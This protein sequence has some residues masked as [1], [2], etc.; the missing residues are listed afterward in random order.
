MSLQ[1]GKTIDRKAGHTQ[2]PNILKEDTNKHARHRNILKQ[3]IF[4]KD[5]NLISKIRQSAIKRTQGLELKKNFSSSE[6]SPLKKKPSL[7]KQ[8]SSSI[9]S[10][11]KFSQKKQLTRSFSL[12]SI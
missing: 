10:P 12:E 3:L 4:K 2:V 9:S 8:T 11:V 7:K 1:K 5:E 6:G